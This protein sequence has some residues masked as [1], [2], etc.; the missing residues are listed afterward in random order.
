VTDAPFRTLTTLTRVGPDTFEGVVDPTWTIGPKVHGGALMG[1]CA[2]AAVQRL[3]LDDDPVDL[4]PLAVSASYL[5]APDP[6]PVTTE[7]TVLKRGRR[8]VH[9]DSVL[10]Q[11][12]KPAVR[13]VVTLGTPDEGEPVHQQH[14]ST[15]ASVL[16]MPVEPPA[17]AP[18]IVPGHPMADIVH[19]AAGCDMRHDPATAH[20]LTGKQGAMEIRMWVRPRPEDE[21]DPATAAL[22][23][24]MTGDICPPVTMNRGLFG[25]APT[26][27]LTTYL[28]RRPAPGWLRVKSSSTVLGGSW[29]E[30]DHTVV[31]STGAVVVQS[32][33]LAMVP[34]A[35]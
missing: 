5:A 29:F 10:M 33:Q 18:Q 24:I 21:N 6:G 3:A 16:D 28:R 31:D 8:V 26:V 23:A 12:G 19:I 2:S 13:G 4:A 35:P 32:R 1:V 9:V 22:F 34:L 14:D 17:S 25:W 30:E 7:T 11:N 15:L 27:Q 20:F